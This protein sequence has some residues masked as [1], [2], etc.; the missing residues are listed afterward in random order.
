ME[1]PLAEKAFQKEKKPITIEQ[2]GL[3]EFT[4]Q[5]IQSEPQLSVTE[6]AICIERTIPTTVL[7][8]HH[9]VR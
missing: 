4:G 9:G 2:F 3:D 7:P 8:Q 6:S 5:S 1:A